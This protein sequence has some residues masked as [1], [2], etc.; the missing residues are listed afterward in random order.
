MHPGPQFE[1]KVVLDSELD[2]SLDSGIPNWIG[3]P[4][5][6]NSVAS[7]TCCERLL[8]S[9]AHPWFLT[10]IKSLGSIQ[11]LRYFVEEH[12]NEFT[13]FKICFSIAP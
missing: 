1:F 7:P 4:Q 2:L 9:S 8:D 6:L 11:F 13:V 5:N 12:K 10:I 3:S